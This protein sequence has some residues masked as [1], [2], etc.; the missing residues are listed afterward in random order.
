MQTARDANEQFPFI[1]PNWIP[2]G[3]QSPICSEGNGKEV[4]DM[5][6]NHSLRHLL[7]Q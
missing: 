4:K 3:R 7:F 1:D 6:K 2:V 5:I